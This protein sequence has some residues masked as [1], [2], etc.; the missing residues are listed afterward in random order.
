M[1]GIQDYEFILATFVIAENVPDAWAVSNNI[2]AVITYFV[3]VFVE[4]N[5][6]IP[7]PTVAVFVSICFSFLIN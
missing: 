4:G 3:R 1:V 2:P 6:G 7:P 5:M